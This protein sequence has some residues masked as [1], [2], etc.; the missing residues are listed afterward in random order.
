MDA[1][2]SSATFFWIAVLVAVVIVVILVVASQRRQVNAKKIRQSDL[3]W[4]TEMRC[5]KC[6]A[7]MEY[8]LAAVQGLRWRPRN[9]APGKLT[10]SGQSVP[11]LATDQTAYI[12]SLGLPENQS[13]R[14]R[15]CSLLAIDHSDRF[16][17]T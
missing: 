10:G 17:V 7:A 12:M 4:P 14:C 9:S 8:G 15:T 13:Y 2:I 6:G 11:N 5:P 16:I 1:S 3:T